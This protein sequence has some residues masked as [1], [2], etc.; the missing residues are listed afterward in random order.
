MEIHDKQA[1]VPNSNL[2]HHHDRP[3][4]LSFLFGTNI[5]SSF[6]VV[7]SFRPGTFFFR[8]SAPGVQWPKPASDLVDRRRRRKQKI[9]IDKNIQIWNWIPFG[10]PS[11]T[12]NQS[13]VWAELKKARPSN[14]IGN[15]KWSP[16]REIWLKQNLRNTLYRMWEI[17]RSMSIPDECLSPVERGVC[18]KIAN[19]KLN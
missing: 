6:S 4:C 19:S 13:S 5:L 14:F 18:H 1:D 15:S 8:R 11:F 9:W 16:L 2:R 7:W 10:N 17:R 3:I 12:V